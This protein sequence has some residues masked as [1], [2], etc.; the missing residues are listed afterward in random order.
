M[1]TNLS[2]HFNASEK[3]FEFI[4]KIVNYLYK[5]YSIDEIVNSSVGQYF[6]KTK[7]KTFVQGNIL[8]FFNHLDIYFI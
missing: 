4:G 5:D 6:L 7:V 8:N 2:N 1:T 3:L